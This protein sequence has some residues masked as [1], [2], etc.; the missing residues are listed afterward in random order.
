MVEPKFQQT[1]VEVDRW[2]SRIGYP[3]TITITAVGFVGWYLWTWFRKP[4]DEIY[5]LVD[6]ERIDEEM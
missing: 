3:L 4:D 5:Q 6:S 2:I 1:G